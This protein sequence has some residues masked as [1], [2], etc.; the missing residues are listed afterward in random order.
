M[1]EVRLVFLFLVGAMGVKNWDVEL[2]EDDGFYRSPN[3]LRSCLCVSTAAVAPS[4]QRPM[5]SSQ[6]ELHSR[7]FHDISAVD[8][9]T[10]C[11]NPSIAA[12]EPIMLTMVNRI[13][14]LSCR[15]SRCGFLAGQGTLVLPCLSIS[16]K[17]CLETWGMDSK[18]FPKSGCIFPTAYR[19]SCVVTTAGEKGRF[20]RSLDGWYI[21]QSEARWLS[22]RKVV[23][24]SITC[25][26][27][28]V[29]RSH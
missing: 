9:T 6:S 18:K 21:S 28:L 13:W 20:E 17:H 27:L 16:A 22:V 5:L 23:Y 24:H 11:P 4:R 12:S 1:F 14:K 15:S 25:A 8:I 10:S 26:V 3:I 7:R 29:Q 2:G 19:R